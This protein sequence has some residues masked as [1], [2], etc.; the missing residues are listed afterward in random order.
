MAQPFF[1]EAGGAAHGFGC[2]AT[3]HDGDHGSGVLLTNLI[4]LHPQNRVCAMACDLEQAEN[5][6]RE[7]IAKCSA[8]QTIGAMVRRRPPSTQ[9]AECSAHRH[10]GAVE[11]EAH[12]SQALEVFMYPFESSSWLFKFS[13]SATTFLSVDS[14]ICNN[15]RRR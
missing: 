2:A 14:D 6:S 4:I 3:S 13:T 12:S 5:V 11:R 15:I 10:L 1:A 7:C 9:T 8:M